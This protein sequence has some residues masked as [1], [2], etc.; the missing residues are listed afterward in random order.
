[1]V[2]T[3]DFSGI[4][5]FLR[6]PPANHINGF[7]NACTS[8]PDINREDLTH[9]DTICAKPLRTRDIRLGVVITSIDLRTVDAQV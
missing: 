8:I 4:Y 2:H 3:D 5:R 6:H 7:S 1:M 9:K